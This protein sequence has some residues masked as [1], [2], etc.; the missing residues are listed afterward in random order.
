[1]TPRET[2]PLATEMMLGGILG[3]STMAITQA[4]EQVYSSLQARFQHFL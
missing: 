2:I 1:M 3:W 4:M